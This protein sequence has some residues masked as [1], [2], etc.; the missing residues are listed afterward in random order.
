MS[1]FTTPSLIII[2]CNKRLAPWLQLEV[3]QLGFTIEK[4]FSTG[5][6]LKGTVNDC[7]KL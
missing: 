1:I 2:T 6:E 3:E 4:T 7:I 5:V